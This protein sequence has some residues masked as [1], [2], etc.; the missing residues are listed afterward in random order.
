[1][2]RNL[3]RTWLSDF[4]AKISYRKKVSHAPRQLCA[5]HI[6]FTDKYDG[7]KTNLRVIMLPKNTTAKLQ[8]CDQRVIRSL[9]MLYHRGLASLILN[10][11][12]K[13]M[14]L[15]EGL[16][17]IRASWIHM[18]T[19]LTPSLTAGR[20]S[21]LAKGEPHS[22]AN[23]EVDDQQPAEEVEVTKTAEIEDSLLVSEEP[24]AELDAFLVDLILYTKRTMQ[25]FNKMTNHNWHRRPTVRS[26]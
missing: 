22:D 10:K 13:I 11:E 7:V 14:S 3:F 15:Y 20:K 24:H 4:N 2:N 8:P 26:S 5:A 1:M 17:L 19:V 25:K 21:H 16:C 9:K 18:N 12:A 6:G 23:Q